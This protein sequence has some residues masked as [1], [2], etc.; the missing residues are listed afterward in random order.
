MPYVGGAVAVGAGRHGGQ[1]DTLH[2]IRVFLQKK[3]ALVV[4]IRSPHKQLGATGHA[5]AVG[6]IDRDEWKSWRTGLK[7]SSLAGAYDLGKRVARVAKI[8]K[9]GLAAL[10]M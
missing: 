3:G 7:T 4:G 5:N 9:A 10:G 6:E 8:F 2:Q 1:E